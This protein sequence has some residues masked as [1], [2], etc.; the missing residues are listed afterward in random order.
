M[1]DEGLRDY[2]ALR[3][4][5]YD[6]IYRKPERQEDLAELRRLLPPL[7]AGR[8]VL[9]IA[10]GTGYWTEVIAGAARSVLAVDAAGEV[11]ALARRRGLQAEK[12]RFLE[13]DAYHPE[14]LPGRFDAALAGF[15]WSHVPRR[16]LSRF[17][18]TLHRRLAPGARVVFLDN[19]YVEGSSTPLCWADEEGNTYQERPLADGSLHRVLKNF[20]G[21]AELRRAVEPVAASLELH[22][23]TYFWLLSYDLAV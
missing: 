4:D 7:L 13:G 21:E 20:P 3:A 23:L 10:C 14:R 8:E 12:T 5:E 18:G 15:W 17:L 19:L 16:R 22:L 1:S 9:E 11:L 6:A 2:Y